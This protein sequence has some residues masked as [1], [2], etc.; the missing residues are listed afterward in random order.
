MQDKNFNIRMGALYQDLF[1][2]MEKIG[3]HVINVTESIT[4]E[5]EREIRRQ[6]AN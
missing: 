2:S 4:G 6:E 1:Q 3:D 5:S